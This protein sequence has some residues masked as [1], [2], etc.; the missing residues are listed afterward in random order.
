MAVAAKFKVDSITL[1]EGMRG[2]R[3]SAV[4]GAPNESWSK[5]TPSGQLEFT[6]TNPEAFTQ[7]EVGKAYLL[8]FEES[9]AKS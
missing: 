5:W 3:M 2:I 8:T 4:H 9:P 1:H 6:I 7:F